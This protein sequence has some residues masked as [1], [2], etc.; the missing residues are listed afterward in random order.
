VARTIGFPTGGIKLW[1]DRAGAEIDLQLSFK[2]AE[3]VRTFLQK[4]I[5]VLYAGAIAESIQGGTIRLEVAKSL[6]DSPH[7]SAGHDFAK[8]KEL[9]RLWVGLTYPDATQHQYAQELATAAD[10]LSQA[11]AQIIEANI[12]VIDSLALF[13]LDELD[14][15]VKTGTFANALYL[16]KTA[17]DTFLATRSGS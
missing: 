5:Q 6:L 1:P 13:F 2:T 11:A 12:G 15:S 8:I 16:P 17:V 10:Q 7:A 9:L 14:R 3:Q 4:R